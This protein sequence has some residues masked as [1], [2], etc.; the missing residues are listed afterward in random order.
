MFDIF[1]DTGLRIGDAYE[2]GRQHVKNGVIS[3]DTEKTGTRVTIPLLAPLAA[4]LKAGPT[5]DLT[6]ILYPAR[7]GEGC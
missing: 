3:I 7:Q 5:G 4:T 2:L 6:F 1:V